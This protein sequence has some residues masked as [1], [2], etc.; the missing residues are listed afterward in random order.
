MT[1]PTP[2]PQPVPPRPPGPSPEELAAAAAAYIALI[3]PWLDAV[4]AAVF[5][6]P[7]I[8]DPVGA[9]SASAAWTA[10]MARWFT[11]WVTPVLIQQ[12]TAV[13]GPQ[14]RVLFHQSPYMIQYARQV[15]NL[16]SNVPDEVYRRI[17][18][19]VTE[20]A[21]SGTPVPDTA[22]M[23][24]EE[25]LN[26]GAAMW[27]NRATVIARTELRRAQEGGQFDSYLH[28]GT[29]NGVELIKQ[30]LDS[31]D[32]RVR[33]AHVDTDGQRRRLTQPFAVGTTNGP[34]YPAMYPLDPILPPSL[35]I[36]CRCTMLIEEAGERMTDPS[37]RG[38][39][40]GR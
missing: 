7:G 32:A 39:R 20:A 6:Q 16:L 28:W 24:N 2:P 36:Q 25:L 4:R 14:G 21:A 37:N 15:Q 11:G 12:F 8:I 34:K 13:N 9:L 33:P 38:F 30:W 26:A 23:I 5:P 17:R 22:E 31:D 18:D 19:I 40:G 29:A 10:A 3:Q 27:T 35:S 1:T